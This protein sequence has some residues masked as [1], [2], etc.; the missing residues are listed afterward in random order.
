MNHLQEKRAQALVEAAA[1]L[2]ADDRQPAVDGA[3]VAR[4]DRDHRRARV[5]VVDD[6]PRPLD[7]QPVSEWR[8]RRHGSLDG[9]EYLLHWPTATRPFLIGRSSL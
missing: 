1:A 6:G 4:Q 5:Q 7:V 2:L 9:A 8:H 3:V